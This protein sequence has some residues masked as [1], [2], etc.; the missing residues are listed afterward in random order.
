MPPGTG[1]VVAVTQVDVPSLGHEDVPYWC[2]LVRDEDGSQVLIKRDTAL[3]V[4]E[5]V[6]LAGVQAEDLSVV[7][8]LGTGIMGRGLVELLLSRGHEVVWVSRSDEALAKGRA[9][10]A[11]RLARVMDEDELEAVT[12]RL[13]T[14]AAP[15]V[16]VRC[17]VV[18]EAVIEELEPKAEALASAESAMRPDAVLATNTS[19]L[20]LDELA[21]HLLLPERFGALHFF[22]PPSRMRL[23]ETSGCS[24]TSPE[25]LAFLDAFSS[26]L[27]K[28]PVRVAQRPAFVVNRVLMPLI[29]EAIRSLE[30]GAASPEAI[31]EAVRLGLNHPMG[32]LALADLIGLDVVLSIME[33]LV[34]RTGDL[35][36]EPRPMLRSL[37][38]EGKLGRKT[39]EG[40]HRY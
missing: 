29:N 19:G 28:V 6:A 27:G 21:H 34:E 13:V 30:E 14:S 7:G 32:P 2:A 23:V 3:N 8:V 4:G 15:D 37:V 31:D 20:P 33:N 38:H 36:N 9:R 22:N 16:F 25:T 5:S 1:T 12:S 35:A 17:D 39:G 11:E 18:I 26:S 10:V 40:F 24:A